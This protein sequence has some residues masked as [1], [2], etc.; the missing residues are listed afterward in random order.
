MPANGRAAHACMW[1]LKPTLCAMQA[2]QQQYSSVFRSL[3]ALRAAEA[4]LG[5]V[6]QAC[7]PLLSHA[8][9]STCAL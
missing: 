1:S 8:G 7:R 5:Q 6:H 3:L 4:G 2:H 9:G